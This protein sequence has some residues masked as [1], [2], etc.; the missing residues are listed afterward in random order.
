[1]ENLD[2]KQILMYVGAAIIIIE[3]VL[4][5]IKSTE[6]NSSLGVVRAILKGIMKGFK[7]K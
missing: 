2:V 7:K 5:L 4:P 1:M 3:Q 6:A